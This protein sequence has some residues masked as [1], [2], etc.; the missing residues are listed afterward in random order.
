M[1]CNNMIRRKPLGQPCDG[2]VS[3]V[4]GGRLVCN[5]CGHDYGQVPSVVAT[6]DDE[7]VILAA[8]NRKVH[9]G[10][11]GYNRPEPVSASA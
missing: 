5:S 6:P 10:L 9:L 8:H 3:G 7:Q 4:I 1:R 2:V 11:D